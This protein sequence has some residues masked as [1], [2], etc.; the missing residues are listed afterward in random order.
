MF[1]IFLLN[2]ANEH[3]SR[4]IGEATEFKSGAG[5]F[6]GGQ[7][8]FYPQTWGATIFTPPCYFFRTHLKKPK[9]TFFFILGGFEAFYFFWPPKNFCFRQAGT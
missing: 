4:E 3:K 5:I 7:V 9:I 2:N 8:F 1:S 6:L